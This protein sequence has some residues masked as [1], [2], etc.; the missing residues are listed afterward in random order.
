MLGVHE[1]QLRAWE[2]K[3]LIPVSEVYSFTE[4]RALQ[5]LVELSRGGLRAE[6]IRLSMHA[7][8]ERLLLDPL[9]EAKLFLQGARRIGV[10]AEGL[11]LDPVTGQYLLDF[12]S[13]S[14]QALPAKNTRIAEA[15]RTQRHRREA[16]HWFQ[17]GLQAEQ[18]GSN[19]R[20]IEESYRKCLE[21]DPKFSS[22][23]VNLG[24][25]CFNRGRHAEAETCYKQAVESDPNY[26]LAHFNLANLHDERG[27]PDQALAHYV[28][29]L[30][31]N[32]DYGDAHYN[33][34]LLYQTRTEFLKALTHWKKYLKLDPGSSWAAIAR[35][36]MARLRQL[37]I[38][39][40]SRA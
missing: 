5:T 13:P 8:R 35:R 38:H 26:A 14:M 12:D 1:M 25:L 32:P 3:D 24:T 21:F 15:E 28:K 16:E 27:E 30:E 36:E 11:V 31:L 6:R 37:T 22:A 2:R 29:A 10:R 33:V 9:T 39:E 23:L 7:V 17:R 40:G 19:D 18:A 4:L 20:L 34:A